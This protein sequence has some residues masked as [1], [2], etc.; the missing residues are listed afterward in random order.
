MSMS[1]F[2][3]D[4]MGAFNECNLSSNILK[5]VLCVGKSHTDP[6]KS[7][8]CAARD[9]KKDKMLGIWSGVPSTDDKADNTVLLEI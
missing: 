5:P 2:P 8:F 1:L 7:G 4:N 9:L 3:L 6:E